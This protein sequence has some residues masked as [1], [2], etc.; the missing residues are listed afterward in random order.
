MVD[1]IKGLCKTPRFLAWATDKEM[2]HLP[3]GISE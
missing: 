3:K 1:L 2:M